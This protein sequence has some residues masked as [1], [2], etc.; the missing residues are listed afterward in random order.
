MLEIDRRDYR[1]Q[2]MIGLNQNI[3]G[4]IF[5]SQVIYVFTSLVNGHRCI[6]V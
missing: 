1:Q 5:H 3:R 2:R 4:M 6:Q